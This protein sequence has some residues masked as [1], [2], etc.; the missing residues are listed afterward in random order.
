L[1]EC[2]S[3][4]SLAITI[5]YRKGTVDDS[6][7]VFQVFTQSIMDLGTR[8]NTMTITGGS[9]PAILESLWQT[10]RSMFEFLARDA[11][12]FWVA[13][14]AE[15]IV[16]YARSME[17]DGVLDLTEFFVLPNQQ[18]GGVGRELL[19]RAFPK[20]TAR[21]R[22]IIATLDERALYRYLNAGVYARFPIKYFYR[23]AEKVHV[24]TD[25]RVE[26][27]RL[28]VHLQDINR[29]DQQVIGHVRGAIHRW[30]ATTREGYV[31]KR[32]GQ[33]VGYGYV[34]ESTGPFAVLDEN[35][36]AAVLAHAESH[37]AEQGKEF[38]SETPLINR[39]AIEYFVQ[40]KYKI[41]S[42]TVLFMSNEPFGKFENYLCFSPVFFL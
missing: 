11:A 38:G 42:F 18:S 24:K 8:T 31:Y 6:Q 7:A 35:D 12:Q 4:R 36:F 22:V 34:G 32:A 16:G 23:K 3:E 1:A 29:I 20:S 17:H 25:L 41:D 19:A 26:P 21:Y 33:I 37:M 39:K 28:D 9:N 5:L 40:H 15:E 27:M 13:E 14:D 10:R 30:V 2:G